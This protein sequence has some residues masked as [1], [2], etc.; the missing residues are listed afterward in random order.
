MHPSHSILR[1]FLLL[2]SFTLLGTGCAY[3]PAQLQID[4]ELQVPPDVIGSGFSIQV[5]GID[6]LPS[7]VLGSLGGIYSE[8][9]KLTLGN[10]I[11]ATM[12]TALSDGFS[13]WS[14]QPTD[15]AADVQVEASLTKLNY[16][17][18]NKLYSTQANAE[19]EVQLKITIGSASYYGNYHS[20]GKNHKLI[21]PSTQEM[22]ASI[23][24]LLSAT[25]QRAFVDEKL[26]T[27]LRQHL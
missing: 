9:S 23:N 3:S 2:L 7:S 25:L 5:R 17:R 13:A 1:A 4:P 10:D 14:F 8:S 24:E 27:F 20:S 26:K 16:S 18:P 15:S 6:Q 22:E 19:A 21:K 12:A 11:E